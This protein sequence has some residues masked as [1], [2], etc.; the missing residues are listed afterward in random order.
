MPNGA[1]VLGFHI[2]SCSCRLLDVSIVRRR[3][4]GG[5][6]GEEMEVGRGRVWFRS[7]FFPGLV[8]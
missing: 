4:H 3:G 7:G 6:E 8:A 5:G 2:P 1:T